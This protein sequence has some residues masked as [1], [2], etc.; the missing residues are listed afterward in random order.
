MLVVSVV[1]EVRCWLKVMSNTSE[2][3]GD[4]SETI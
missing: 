3:S 1:G 4:L 2:V